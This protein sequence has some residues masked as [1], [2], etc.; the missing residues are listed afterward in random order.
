MLVQLTYESQQLM[1]K[2]KS[3]W[4]R[5]RVRKRLDHVFVVL[6]VMQKKVM[7]CIYFCW[8]SVCHT[9]LFLEH[10]FTAVHFTA[11][12]II[13]SIQYCSFLAGFKH[14]LSPE[15]RLVI[16]QVHC[17]QLFIL[18]LQHT[19]SSL[20]SSCAWRQHCSLNSPPLALSP[21]SHFLTLYFLSSQ[22]LPFLSLPLPLSLTILHAPLLLAHSSAC[23]LN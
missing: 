12:T 23:I 4:V 22:V 6:S 18:P 17:L 3:L 20:I 15:K 11:W 19:C 16:L 8:C 5:V 2:K 1:K 21:C 9:A 13:C 14:T 10:L 7:F